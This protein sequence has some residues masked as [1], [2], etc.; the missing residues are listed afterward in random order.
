[1]AS[2]SVWV[3]LDVATPAVAN[4]TGFMSLGNGS[5]THYP[6]VN[7]LGYMNVWRSGGRV[8]NIVLNAAIDRT[9]WHQVTITSDIGGSG[10]WKMYQN[11]VE[12]WDVAAQ[13]LNLPATPLIGTQNGFDLDGMFD[14]FRLS[15]RVRGSN[16][17]WAAWNNVA[18]NGTFNRYQMTSGGAIGLLNNINAVNIMPDTAD[19]TVSLNATG[20]LYGVYAYWNTIDGGTN[21]GAWSNRIHLGDYS[22]GVHPVVHGLTGL[23][24]NTTYFYTFRA[25]NCANDVWADARTFKTLGVP[26]IDNGSG[27]EVE[28]GEAVLNGTLTDGGEG[29]VIVFWGDSDGGTVMANWENQ[30]TLGVLTEG[31]FSTSL[32]NLLYG[33]CYYYRAYVTNLLGEAWAPST[34]NFMTDS[35]FVSRPQDLPGLEL[36]LDASRLGINDGDVAAFWPDQSG[37]S[38]HMDVIS[39]VGSDPRYVTNGLN[40]HPVVRYDGNDWQHTSHDFSGMGDHTIFSVARYTNPAGGGAS[41]RVISALGQNWLFGFWGNGDERW[42]SEG[43][44]HQTGNNNTNWH[45]H[46]GTLSDGADPLAAFWKDGMLLTTNDVGSGPPHAPRRITFGAWQNN[47]NESSEAEIAEL[48][49]YD[50]VLNDDEIFYV[51]DYLE[52]K[53]AL[54][55]AFPAA[56][57]FSSPLSNAAA[58]A[59]TTTSAVLNAGL[60]TEDSVFDVT[61][62]Y[63]L[64]DGGSDP[65]AWDQAI[66]LGWFTNMNMVS[67]NIPASGLMVD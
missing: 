27:A 26:A 60:N 10:R 17:I 20:A 43:W 66:S 33:A 5:N 48:I 13:N 39:G 1:A 54:S 28:V 62:F 46:T 34:T 36:W 3:K 61:V 6:W 52:N 12:I 38:Y 25:S 37:N 55:S 58:T 45:I 24:Q 8:D 59:V 67:F 15:N 41:E 4:N 42:F 22:N 32:T 63:G 56:G 18:A 2:I 23:T 47:N 30:V 9:Q 16:W 65:A 29:D 14:E 19:I 11:G 7:G 31:G 44:I 21:V 35:P 40:G 57:P 53:Y 64:S 50:R 49:I 51:S